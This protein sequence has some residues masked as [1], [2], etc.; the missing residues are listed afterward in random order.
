MSLWYTHGR[1][2]NDKSLRTLLEE[3]EAIGNSRRLTVVL[4]PPGH[5]VK[6][7][8]YSR[9]RGKRI[10]HIANEFWVRLRKEFLWSRRKWN[11]KHRNFQNGDIVLLKSNANCNQ[12]PM[13]KLV[14]INSDAEGFVRSVKLLIAKTRND[15]E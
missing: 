2:L 5:F 3:I 10:Q 13:A 4:P 11:E 7:E 12:W 14:G 8:E 6:A 15:G 9:K 1:S